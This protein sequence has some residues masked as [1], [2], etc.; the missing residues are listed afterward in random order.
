MGAVTLATHSESGR[1]GPKKNVFNT[2]Y[3]CSCFL[4]RAISS[5][6]EVGMCCLHP[7]TCKVLSIGFNP[8]NV[9]PPRPTISNDQIY[10]P[11]FFY[12]KTRENTWSLKAPPQKN[13]TPGGQSQRPKYNTRGYYIWGGFTSDRV[14][15]APH[16]PRSA[17]VGA[18]ALSR[19]C[20]A[21]VLP[22]LQARPRAM[23]P[24]SE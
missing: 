18:M 3:I 9:T 4:W 6:E 22:A 12:K 17:P 21:I 15:L 7:H 24:E 11:C 14:G 20:T 16:T 1:S 2:P 19:A 13:I 10:P 5:G 23:S 8:P